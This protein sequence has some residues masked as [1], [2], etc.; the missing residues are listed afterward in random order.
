MLW[1][2][3][4]PLG[5]PVGFL[6][7]RYSVLLTFESLSLFYLILYLDLNVLVDDAWIS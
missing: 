4:G 6:L 7:L 5:L 2:L 1:L 3:L